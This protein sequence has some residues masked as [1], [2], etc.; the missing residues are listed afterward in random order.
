MVE[1]GSKMGWLGVFIETIGLN[2]PWCQNCAEWLTGRRTRRRKMKQ[3][4]R[5]RR[6]TFEKQLCRWTYAKD[7]NCDRYSSFILKRVKKKNCL[8]WSSPY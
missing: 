8:V 1:L 5:R 3:K 4:R 2:L 7:H 6:R